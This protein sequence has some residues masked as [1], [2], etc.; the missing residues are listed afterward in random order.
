MKSETFI[1]IEAGI[2]YFKSKD[3]RKTLTISEVVAFLQA[4]KDV[5]RY[6]ADNAVRK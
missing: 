2:A 1:P 6:K 5:E 4:I 3:Q